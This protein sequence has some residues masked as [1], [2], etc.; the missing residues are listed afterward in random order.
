MRNL[1]QHTETENSTYGF[2]LLNDRQRFSI[3]E[4]F[5][6]L[7]CSINKDLKGGEVLLRDGEK[8][9]FKLSMIGVK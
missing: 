5:D 9:S 1:T 4:N 8:V 3:C 7:H 6:F 2:N